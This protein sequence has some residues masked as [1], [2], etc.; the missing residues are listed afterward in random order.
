MQRDPLRAKHLLASSSGK[1]APAF[2][3]ASL[4]MIMNCRPE[5]RRD[6]ADHA[7]GRCA[8]PFLVHAPRGK[9]AEFEEL[10][11]GIDQG[12][13]PLAG[14]ETTFLMLPLD[15]RCP[16]PCAISSRSRASAA[17]NSLQ[18]FE[19]FI[20]G[21]M[22]LY[23]TSVAPAEAAA[24]GRCGRGPAQRHLF[25]WGQYI[26]RAEIHTPGRFARR[27]GFSF[28]RL[29]FNIV[30][31]SRSNQFNSLSKAQFMAS[32]KTRTVV[33]TG[34]TRGLGRAMVN[35]FI[36]LGHTVIGCG[37]SEKAIAALSQQHGK[38]HRFDALDIAADAAVKAW[39][40]SAVKSSS[41][42]DLLCNNAAVINTNAPLWEVPADEFSNVVDVNIKGVTNVIRHFLPAMLE[43]GTGVVVNFSSGWGRSTSAEV[44]PY[45]A[46]KWAI[47]GLTQALAQ[48][49]P[50]GMCAVPLN[51]GI[52]NTEMLQSCFGASA[53]DYPDPER[54]SR[55][56][57]PFLLSLGPKDN[58]QPVT[59]PL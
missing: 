54:W 44:A 50:D 34:V 17:N 23:G 25:Q 4:A 24:G 8:A 5:T 38:P 36:E 35:R 41:A 27:V 7:G 43:R 48:E 45:C 11:S 16:P 30:N 46:T 9:A 31:G 59:V 57:V 56:A 33:I 12:C 32:N 1:N 10:G 42:P 37:R 39:A 18:F 20:R 52:I 28:P 29:S 51:P 6:A 21:S 49:L 53:D 3:V 19:S 22:S 2:T 15:G 55:V 47:E 13:D 40:T 58:G 26:E 14:R